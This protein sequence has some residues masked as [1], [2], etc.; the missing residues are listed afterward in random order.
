MLTIN[1]VSDR[2]TN[3]PTFGQM[4]KR[5]P[6]RKIRSAMDA[7]EQWR[8]LKNPEYSAIFQEEEACTMSQ[9]T[10]NRK[11]RLDNYSFLDELRSDYDKKQFISHF[12]NVTGFPNLKAVT[13]KILEEFRRVLRVA[14]DKFD[15]LRSSSFYDNQNVLMSGYDEF[16]SVGQESALPGSDL[17]KGY[18][19]VRGIPGDLYDQKEFSN[20][21]K[22]AIWDN[23]DNRIMSVNHTAAFPNIM[24]DKEL[25]ESINYFDE[26]AKEF[27][28]PSNVNYYRFIRLENGNPVAGSKFNITLSERLTSRSDRYDAKN[29]AYVVEAMRDGK[30][31]DMVDYYM[32]QMYQLFENSPFCHCSNVTQSHVMQDLYDYSD[33]TKKKLKARKEVEGAF[34]YWSVDRQY[35]LVKDIIRSMSG[36]SINPEFK[37]LF[38]SANDHHRLL[39]NDIL[40]GK[41]G[42]RFETTK[43]G[44]NA[45]LDFR[46]AETREKY[47]DFNIYSYNY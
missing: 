7:I 3:V 25:A 37:D 15:C 1:P 44:E 16:C 28:S 35:E 17:D 6:H 46:D 24:T 41:V 5:L 18:A 14:N 19:I 30:K 10:A 20:K 40:R 29:L 38:H 32:P 33:I 9:R 2:Q 43:Y 39:I 36:D 47:S 23:I 4:A 22:G 8:L 34:N 21:I 26:Y 45:V 13:G 11:L 27:V 31:L 42:C 12:R